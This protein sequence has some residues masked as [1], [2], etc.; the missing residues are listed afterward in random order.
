LKSGWKKYKPK[1]DGLGDLGTPSLEQGKKAFYE[2]MGVIEEYGIT[3]DDCNTLW[4]SHLAM[5]A[6]L[7]AKEGRFPDRIDDVAHMLNGRA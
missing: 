4:Q 6:F 5:A 2:I 7:L 3:V 1:S